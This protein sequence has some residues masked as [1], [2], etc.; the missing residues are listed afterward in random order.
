M[1]LLHL[2]L[3]GWPEVR[4]EDQAVA[5][6]TRKALA[7]LAYLAV[8]G[9]T[10]SREKLTAL[11]W[12]ESDSAQGRATL[13]STLAHLRTALGEPAAHLVAM[14]ET[15][16]LDPTLPC[17]LDVQLLHAAARARVGTGLARPGEGSQPGQADVRALL[18][19]LRA[20]AQAVRGDFLEGFSLSDAPEFDDWTSVQ[21]EA[22]H[23]QAALV[24]DQLSRLQFHTGAIGDAIETTSRWIARDR[25]SEAAYRRL[26]R[27]HIAAGDRN[28]ALEAYDTCRVTLERELQADPSPETMTLARRIRQER[29]LRAR[30]E[31]RDE[32]GPLVATG[33]PGGTASPLVGRAAEHLALVAAYEAARRRQTGMALLAGEP[34]IGKSRLARDFLAWA[35]AQGADILHS[36]AFE[37]GG[38][39]PYHPLVEAL[40]ER[41]GREDDP[42]QLVSDTWLA[43]LSRLLPEL[44]ERLPGLAQPLAI[45]DAEARLRLFEAVARIGQASAGRA[46]LVWFL[47]D[48]Q[49]ADAATLDLLAYAARRW[50]SAQAPILLLFA[51]RT[52][53]LNIAA[54][55][56]PSRAD[57]LDALARDLPLARLPLGPLTREGTGRLV[58]ALTSAVGSA[59][60]AEVAGWF[61][62]E[63]AGQPFYIVQTLRALAERRVL[64]QDDAGAWSFVAALP[65]FAAQP[66]Q[67]VAEGVRALIR[68]RLARLD[69]TALDVCTAGAI[70][71]DG[72]DFEVLRRVADQSEAEHL[73][74]LEGLLQRGLLRERDGRYAFTHDK[75][76]EVA[77]AEISGPRRRILHRRALAALADAGAPPAVLARHAL[78]GEL[79]ADAARHSLAAGDDALRLFAVR[80]AIAHYE[81]ARLL[82]GDTS[83]GATTDQREHLYLQLGRA[84]EFVNDWEQASATYDALLALSRASR[85]PARECDALNRLATVRAQGSFDLP[86]AMGLLAQAQ[87]AAERSGDQLRLAE[88][89]WNQAQLTFYAWRLE[90]CL[91]HGERALALAES[92]ANPDLTARCLNIVGYAHMMLAH[93]PETEHFA[94]K[95]RTLA[96]TLDNRVIEIDCLSILTIIRVHAGDLQGGITAGQAGLALGRTIE[97][98]WG[99]ANCTH[100]LAQGLLDIGDI[101]AALAIAQEGLAAAQ[102]AGH[103]PTIVFN[104]ITLGNIFRALFSP[105]QAQQF[106]REALAIGEAL[107]HPLLTEWSLIELNADCALAGDGDAAASHA[108]RAIAIRNHKQV[109]A[110]IA[111]WCETEAL[112]H[113][114]EA[115]LAI[116]DIARSRQHPQTLP[117]SEF[118]LLRC[119]AVLAE[120]RNDLATALVYLT[121]AL[122]LARDLG[123]VPEHWQTSVA[124]GDALLRHGDEASSHQAYRE[125]ATIVQQI[126]ARIP[127]PPL[128]EAFLAAPPAQRALAH[129]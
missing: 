60:P 129:A 57:W 3:L 122:M 123:L 126:A 76:R 10:H 111:R 73:T 118:Q 117:R 66:P 29:N 16:A 5:F 26:M 70:V 113:S 65:A 68:T 53:D 47:D 108:R 87:A 43:E 13:R 32:I 49:W 8:E 63:T 4:H 44:P 124:L 38:T 120:A 84:Y 125:A 37:T 20:A 100:A 17:E 96:A 9:G 128:R 107:H 33:E 19:P 116:A 78:A 62:A 51:A 31:R 103:P 6:P 46:P 121:A 98:P 97:N 114:G 69:R 55:G 42:R 58:A 27:L 15:I 45:G 28:A 109:Y 25:L 99:I 91:A 48:L 115:E 71:G 112:L 34:G 7:L 127:E 11:F 92:L 36:R 67:P 89:N 64:R 24:F 2:A 1:G 102:I 75:I 56:G 14:R 80:T 40:R 93:V 95:A 81:Q 52:E 77:Y 39:L 41:I 119:E 88:T 61:F 59:L 79:P 50:S 110:G 104:L 101:G 18:A 86:G 21:R 72:G 74:A 54:D 22:M 12:P 90:E 85:Q 105:E 30:D 106:H 94:G 23:R 83:I 35:A 82:L